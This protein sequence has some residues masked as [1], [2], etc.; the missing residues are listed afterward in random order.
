V[1]GRGACGSLTSSLFP[2]QGNPHVEEDRV[3]IPGKCPGRYGRPGV[4]EEGKQRREREE[5][6]EQDRGFLTVG[7]TW[8]SWTVSERKPH[9]AHPPAS[10]AKPVLRTARRDEGAEVI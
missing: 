10:S 6:A 8:P 4:R 2:A 9:M 3:R 5:S 7:H 1:A